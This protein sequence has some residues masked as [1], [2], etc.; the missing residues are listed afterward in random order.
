MKII[1]KHWKTF[2]IW[3]T[4]KNSLVV[5]PSSFVW[6]TFFIHCLAALDFGA[7]V[8]QPFGS[9]IVENRHAVRGE[10]GGFMGGRRGWRF[11]LLH[12]THRAQRRPYPNCT[13]RQAGAETSDIGAEA[14]KPDPGSSWE[15]HSGFVRTGVCN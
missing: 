10:I 6:A 2:K 5:S 3:S 7:G 8:E 9:L 12:H 14:V 11:G 1:K 4:R 13:S 15:G